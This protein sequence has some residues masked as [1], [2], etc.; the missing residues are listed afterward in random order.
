MTNFSTATKSLNKVERGKVIEENRACR[1]CLSWSH[2]V[3]SC[4]LKV[5]SC[6]EK[7]N[8][9]ECK[10][11]HSKLICGSGIMYC[12]SVC[13]FDESVDEL[14]PTVPLMDD[15]VV[16]NG[17]ARTVYDGGSQRVLIDNTFAAEQGL[18]SEDVI[19]NLELAGN[20][21]ERL[22]TRMYQL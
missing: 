15:I 22:E 3:E 17:T 21:T 16:R 8:G 6:K 20:K 14:I 7:I 2:T 12:L 18:K 10:K 1:R 5:T 11:D 4:P 13:S 19:V 9:H